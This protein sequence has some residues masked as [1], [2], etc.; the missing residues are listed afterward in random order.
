MASRESERRAIVKG[1]VAQGCTYRDGSGGKLF[2]YF[3]DGVGMTTFHS[4]ISDPRALLNLRSIIRKA[5]LS[6]PLDNSSRKD[7]QK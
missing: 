2:I 1:L 5:G 3:P 7:T 6:W 4:S